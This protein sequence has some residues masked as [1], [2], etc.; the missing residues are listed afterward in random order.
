VISETIYGTDNPTNR[1]PTTAH[2]QVPHYA[3]SL[4]CS[5]AAKMIRVSEMTASLCTHCTRGMSRAGNGKQTSL[6]MAFEHF[7][8]CWQSHVLWQTVPKPGNNRK[9]DITLCCTRN[10]HHIYRSNQY[11]HTQYLP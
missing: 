9:S 5:H 3:A 8:W 4:G 6:K 2:Q 11:V 10:S 7:Y 1:H